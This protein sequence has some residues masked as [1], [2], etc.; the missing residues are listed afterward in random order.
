MQQVNQ[1]RSYF[2]FGISGQANFYTPDL[3][4]LFHLKIP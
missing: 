2:I 1:Y 4:L 3:R